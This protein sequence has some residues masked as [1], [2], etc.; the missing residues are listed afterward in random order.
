MT[1]ETFQATYSIRS[2]AKEECAHEFD[3]GDE[4]LNDNSAQNIA[5]S[6]ST[7]AILKGQQQKINALSWMRS[8]K[9]KSSHS[10]EL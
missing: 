6:F 2:L 3:C 1:E 9:W 10:I 4:D 8:E 7:T 5:L